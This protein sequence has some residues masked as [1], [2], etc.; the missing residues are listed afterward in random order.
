MSVLR[1]ANWVGE[2]SSPRT[3]LVFHVSGPPVG[4]GFCAPMQVFG[5]ATGT[6][7]AA[8][9]APIGSPGATIPPTP[10]RGAP[11]DDPPSLSATRRRL[12]P[13]LRGPPGNLGRLQ[14]TRTPEHHNAH[15]EPALGHRPA[16]R[17]RVHAQRTESYADQSVTSIVVLRGSPS[18]QLERHQLAT[19]LTGPTETR[20]IPLF[21]M[22]RSPRLR[23]VSYRR[24][25]PSPR[26]G[27]TEEH[28][29]GSRRTTR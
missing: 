16:G 13:S 29:S 7:Q 6:R 3:H 12:G 28:H 15:R 22:Q 25:H 11:R 21:R 20:P 9:G 8:L 24:S 10:Q 1:R 2:R 26:G 19:S 17:I 23:H 14:R 4:S 5:D 27:P 18:L